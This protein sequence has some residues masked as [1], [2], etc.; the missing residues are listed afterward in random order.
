MSMCPMCGGS[1]NKPSGRESNTCRRCYGSGSV[2]VREDVFGSKFE[3]CPDCGGDGKQHVGLVG[4]L[5]GLLLGRDKCPMCHGSGR[6]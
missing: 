2:K 5:A 1:G 4:A 3:T 6:V